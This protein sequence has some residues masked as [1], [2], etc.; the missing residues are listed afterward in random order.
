M[1]TT[2]GDIKMELFCELI[3]KNAEVCRLSINNEE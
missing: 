1:H 3:P 2:L